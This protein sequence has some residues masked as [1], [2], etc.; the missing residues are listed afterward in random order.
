MDV[1]KTL[2]RSARLELDL[3]LEA[4][5]ISEMAGNIK[6]DTGFVIP[7]LDWEHTSETVLTTSWVDGIPIRDHV[8]I[9]AAGLDRKAL[10]KTL[11]Q[12]VPRRMRS[13]T[14]SSTAICIRAI[15]SPIPGPAS[16]VAV[17][18][19]IMGRITRKE[20]RFL[21]DILYGFITRNYRLIARAAFRD[22]LCAGA[23]IGG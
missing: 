19:G 23:S 13:A 17:D 8:A 21:A 12:S 15:S 14:A 22:R 20:R 5:S 3:R 2:D 18:F 1:V 7:G 11:L 4:A 16:I 9:D 10:A 6:D